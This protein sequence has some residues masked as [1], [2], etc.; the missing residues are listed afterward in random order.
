MDDKQAS[1]ANEPPRKMSGPQWFMRIVA[2]FLVLIA[3]AQCVLR[4]PLS[5][6]LA[7]LTFACLFLALERI[8]PRRK[9]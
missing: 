1:A 5:M 8:T 9:K 7:P 3:I 6:I 4:S 2:I